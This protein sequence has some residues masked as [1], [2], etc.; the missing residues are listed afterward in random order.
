MRTLNVKARYMASLKTRMNDAVRAVLLAQD[1]LSL[2]VNGLVLVGDKRIITPALGLSFEKV[3]T[4]QSQ[5]CNL[6]QLLAR[7]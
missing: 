1:E 3:R 2:V 5:V 6:Q 7:A 4:A